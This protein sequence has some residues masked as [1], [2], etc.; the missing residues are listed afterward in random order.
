[1]RILLLLIVVLFT[2]CKKQVQYIRGSE[3]Q[4]NF[5]SFVYQKYPLFSKNE[6]Q[7]SE[8]EKV[9]TA[10][11]K[12]YISDSLTNIDGFLMKIK[13]IDFHQFNHEKQIK[14]VLTD[15]RKHLLD[16]DYHDFNRIDETEKDETSA[17]YKSFIDKK[18]NDYVFVYGKLD[19]V[20]T[21]KKP[22]QKED[23]KINIDSVRLV[24]NIKL[25]YERRKKIYY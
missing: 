24:K 13:R 19:K 23:Y 7:K 6:I 8:I 22:F 20:L 1:M 9:F 2:G 3:T 14:V 17:L 12:K 15:Y 11:M 16:I 18:V 25:I 4:E 10:D 5:I 21:L